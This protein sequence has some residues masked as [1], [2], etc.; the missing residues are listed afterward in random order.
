MA[1][2]DK[3]GLWHDRLKQLNDHHQKKKYGY[4]PKKGATV[5]NRQRES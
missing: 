2:E 1:R 4:S 3:N 5:I